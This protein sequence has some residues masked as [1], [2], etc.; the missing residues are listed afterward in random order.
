MQKAGKTGKLAK[1]HILTSE[2]FAQ[3]PLAGHDIQYKLL[4]IV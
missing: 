3:H 2:Y 1:K 4:I